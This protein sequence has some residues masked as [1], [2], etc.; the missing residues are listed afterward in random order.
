MASGGENGHGSQVI[1]HSDVA[2][3]GRENVLWIDSKDQTRTLNN[4]LTP[5]QGMG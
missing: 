4:Q 2:F 5:C 1:S 3:Q